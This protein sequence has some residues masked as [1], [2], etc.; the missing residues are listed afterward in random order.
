VRLVF[1]AIPKQEYLLIL[2]AQRRFSFSRSTERKREFQWADPGV[3][4]GEG[5]GWKWDAG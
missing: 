5:A 1:V 4:Q 3:V 2:R